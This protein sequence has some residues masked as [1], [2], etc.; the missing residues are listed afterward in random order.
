[1]QVTDTDTFN[2]EIH[3]GKLAKRW[4]RANCFVYVAAGRD[5]A[6]GS[7]I[8]GAASAWEKWRKATGLDAVDN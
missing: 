2:A 3:A 7:G 8:V 6:V 5:R 1:M 4:C